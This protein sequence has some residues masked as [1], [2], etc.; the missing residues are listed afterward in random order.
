MHYYTVL[1][2]QNCMFVS[3][4]LLKTTFIAFLST[5]LGGITCDRCTKSFPVARFRFL[6]RVGACSFS[7]TV[8]ARSDPVIWSLVVERG[9]EE[10]ILRISIST[11]TVADTK[12][13]VATRRVLKCHSTHCLSSD[14]ISELTLVVN[15]N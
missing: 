12:Q 11:A 1:F 4:S 10:L 15:N 3:C 7:P 6:S 8:N 5:C 9:D 13:S 2:K 14:L